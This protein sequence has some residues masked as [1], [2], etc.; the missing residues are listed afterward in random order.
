MFSTFSRLLMIGA[1]AL[2][3]SGCIAAAA[4]AGIAGGAYFEKH[5]KIV[6]K[7]ES[8]KSSTQKSSTSS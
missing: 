2:S 7:N 4:G 5:Y 3:L 1:C 6:K 8:S